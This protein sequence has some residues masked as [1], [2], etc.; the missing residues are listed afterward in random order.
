MK[1]KPK[2]FLC[3]HRKCGTTMFGNLF[4]G[5]CELS[6]FP[7]DLSI[8]YGY[9]PVYHIGDYTKDEKLERLESVTFLNLKRVFDVDD[10]NILDK[11][12]LRKVR[13]IFYENFDNND[14]NKI[15]K[16]LDAYLYSFFS[17][18]DKNYESTKWDVVKETSI[19]IYAQE[20]NNLYPNCKFIQ[21]IRD[22]RDNYA[23][24]KAGSEKHYSRFGESEKHILASLINRYTHG[25]LVASRNLKVL[26]DDKYMVIKYEDLC[27]NPEVIMKRI[28]EFLSIEFSNS[29]LVP[30][31]LSSSTKGN[32]WEGDK[33]YQIT[34]KN[35]NR[36][37]ERLTEKEAKIIEFHFS[38]LMKKYNYLTEYDLESTITEAAE[39]YKWSNYHYYFK[40]SFPVVN[41]DIVI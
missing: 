10:L 30:T 38:S 5:H 14:L 33:F 36:W 7:T 39:F 20:I 23:S 15:E 26:G 2:L 16:I 24:I 4:D 28:S 11:V 1:N 8:F 18:T 21:I 27:N 12:D 22:P 35:I 32:N 37:K 25:L 34:N 6:V 3:G 29:L 17:V 31:V 19:E 40:D 9:Y 13:D 41:K